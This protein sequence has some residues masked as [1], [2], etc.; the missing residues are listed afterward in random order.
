MRKFGGSRI[1][2]RRFDGS[3]QLKCK[4]RS[5]ICSFGYSPLHATEDDCDAANRGPCSWIRY[6]CLESDSSAVEN[7]SY[8]R[9]WSARPWVWF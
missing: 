8:L 5:S 3:E 1:T 2:D 6:I 7:H 9:V 4:M